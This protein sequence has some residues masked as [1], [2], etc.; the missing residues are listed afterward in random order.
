MSNSRGLLKGIY[1]GANRVSIRALQGYLKGSIH[2]PEMVYLLPEVW[3]VLGFFGWTVL[4]LRFGG[5]LGFRVLGG[6][7]GFR[8]L[9]D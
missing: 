9:W 8:G 1:S 4:G 3:G 7:P 5:L 6:V 2:A